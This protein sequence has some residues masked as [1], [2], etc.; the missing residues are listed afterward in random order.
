MVEDMSPYGA[1]WSKNRQLRFDPTAVSQT[2]EIAIPATEESY[3][4]SLYF[5]KGPSYGDATILHNGE[6]VGTIA[7]YDKSTAPGGKIVMKNLKTVDDV[8]SLEFSVTG[9]DAKSSGYSVGLDAFV[10][11]PIRKYIPEWYMIGPFPNPRD[12]NLQRLGLDMVFPP[13][14]EFN[15]TKTYQGVNNQVVGWTLDK[16]PA[17]GRM[18][19]YKYNPFE[20]VI[21]YAVTFIYSPA[22]QTLPLLLGSD[23]GVKVLLNDKEIHRVLV[24]RVAEPDQDRVPVNL[25]KGWNK[26]MLK[27]ENNFGG[28]NFYARVL[29]RKK[30]LVFSPL[31]NK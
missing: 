15:P 25:K 17:S 31:K 19:L 20:L 12:K 21:V 2:M 26:L 22:D 10:M 3:N 18:D 7:G 16:T 24:I 1:D 6:V 23:D 11:E 9:R 27:I 30:S 4:V 8:V 28:Y 29:D 13:E 5:T 14:N